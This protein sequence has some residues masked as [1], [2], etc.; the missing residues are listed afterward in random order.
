MF[1]GWGKVPENY[2]TK[3]QLKA[4]GL[5]PKDESKPDE[6]VYASAG[7]RMN[8][9]DLY[10]VDN[11]IEIKKKKPADISDMDLNSVNIGESLYVVNKSA[12]KSRDTKAANYSLGNHGVVKNAKSRQYNLYDLKDKVINK[13]IQEGV[14][15]VLGYHIHETTVWNNVRHYTYS[16]EEREEMKENNLPWEVY[17]EYETM[18][19]STTVRNHLLYLKIENFFFHIPIEEKNLGD[20]KCLGEMDMVSSE[21]TRKTKITFEQAKALLEKYIYVETKV[22]EYA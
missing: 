5:K 12:L 18:I 15:Q 10:D 22:S 14:A 11:T 8:Y 20:Y 21:I 13:A 6:K 16:E 17:N 2:K 3:T 7:G 4:M 19:E 9:F 1:K